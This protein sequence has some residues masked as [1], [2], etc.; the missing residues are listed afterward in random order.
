MFRVAKLQKSRLY[1][2]SAAD[3]GTKIYVQTKISGSLDLVQN[4]N[5]EELSSETIIHGSMYT[6]NLS[7]YAHSTHFMFFH[8]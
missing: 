2:R 6:G 1:E 4:V 3:V 7:E 8:Y 5:V